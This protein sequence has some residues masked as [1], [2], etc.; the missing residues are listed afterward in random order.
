MIKYLALFINSFLLLTIAPPDPA[1]IIL[2]PLN[3]KIPMSPIVPVYLPLNFPVLYLEAKLSAASSIILIFLFLHN[4]ISFSTDAAFP[5]ICAM[6]IALI[7][8]PVF[9]FIVS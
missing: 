8:F 6:I 1:V 5:Q 9:L 2:L 7:T 3:E 4:G